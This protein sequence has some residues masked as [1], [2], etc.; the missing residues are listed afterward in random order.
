MDITTNL[1][2]IAR[3]VTDGLTICR[4]PLDS[5]H[6]DPANA[7]SHGKANMAAI[8]SSIRRFGQA[9]PLVVQASSGRVIG[10]NGRLVAMQELGFTDCDVVQLDVDDLKA[11]A[12]GIA[13]NRTGELAEWNDEVLARL[14]KEL[15]GLDELDGVGFNDKE[16]DTLLADLHGVGGM[17]TVEDPGPGPLP[18]VATTVLGDLWQLG[19]HRLLC[20]D[21]RS[22]ADGQRVMGEDQA[23]IVWCDPPFGVSYVGGTQ[24]ALTIEN[25]DLTGD[26]LEAFLRDAFTHAVI[27][28]KPG[29][30]WYVAAPAGP[31]FLPFAKV[32]TDLGVWRQTLVWLKDS[33]V[34]GRSDFHYRH[35]ALFYGWTPGA[36]HHAPS[37]RS[38]DTVWEVDR[39][40]SSPDHPTT[41]PIELVE[42]ALLTS[43]DPNAVVL[44]PFAG[45]GTTLL[46]A[47]STNRTARAIELDP[48]YCDVVL[49]RFQEA[50]GSSAVLEE[51]G[52]AFD[53]VMERRKTNELAVD[54]E[55]D[56][57][58]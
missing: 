35:E 36:A 31:N 5:L 30:A 53:A 57:E 3:G 16:I 2:P 23:D 20:G 9:E 25:D 47:E 26:A 43:S 46:A 54:Q 39:P 45:S 44:D 42:R 6:L 33:L 8:T 24:D 48:K 37:S 1:D 7:R 18:A 4:V 13:L 29:A 17:G 49:R 58:N 38:G 14:L 34:L 51:T 40:K 56:H 19:R 10:G 50:T 28:C 11:T 12:L 15:R 55:H 32:L 41:K 27:A 22:Q 52:E 21:S